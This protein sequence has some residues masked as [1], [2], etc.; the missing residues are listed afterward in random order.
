MPAT[1]PLYRQR[2]RAAAVAGSSAVSDTVS[3]TVCI[4]VN[5][6]V[7]YNQPVVGTQSVVRCVRYLER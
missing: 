7:S 5:S 6:T 4:T 3:S 1:V 2:R